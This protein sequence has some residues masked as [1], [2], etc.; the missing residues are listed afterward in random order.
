MHGFR[1]WEVEEVINSLVKVAEAVQIRFLWRTL[2]TDRTDEMVLETAVN[3]QANL[4]VTFNQEDFVAA[5][6]DFALKA[7]RPSEAAAAV[8]GA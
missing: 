8:T 1:E 7:V 3:G 5:T 4:L 2:L 6:K